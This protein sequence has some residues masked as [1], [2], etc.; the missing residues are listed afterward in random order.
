MKLRS[1]ATTILAAGGLLA[2]S[3]PSF[4]VSCAT[5]P[6]VGAW[7]GLGAA[8]CTDPNDA[9]SLWVWTGNTGSVAAT[10]GFSVGEIELAG[11]D[12]YTVSLDWT[13]LGGTT[14]AGTLSYT[15][16]SLNTEQ[17]IAANFDTSVSEATG[18]SGAKAN[19]FVGGVLTL[20]SPD[21]ARDPVTGETPL[22]GGP[23][24][25]LAVLD[26]F[27]PNLATPA[28]SAVLTG[29]INSFQVA[30]P[31]RAPEPATLLLLGAG[32]AGLGLVRRRKSR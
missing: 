10:V 1:L 4:A 2:G 3:G 30:V 23:Y 7:A 25:S 5:V 16:S 11:I 28:G 15:V 8:G 21:G 31:Q 19:A 14:A 22:P 32:L 29:A 27:Q 26:T 24:S 12:F 18:T 6:T 13:V 17:F 9:D 20:S